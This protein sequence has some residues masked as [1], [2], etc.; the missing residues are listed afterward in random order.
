MQKKTDKKHIVYYII[1]II[2]DTG[3]PSVVK[4]IVEAKQ[5]KKNK[6]NKTRREVRKE[7][8]REPRESNRSLRYILYIYTYTIYKKNLSSLLLYIHRCSSIHS[9]CCEKT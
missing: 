7:R 3:R 4:Y 8:E 9:F 5:T 2:I 6:Q 1:T